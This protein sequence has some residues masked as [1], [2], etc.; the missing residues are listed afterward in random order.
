[1]QSLQDAH[2]PERR[3]AGRVSVRP[4]PELRGKKQPVPRLSVLSLVGKD[5]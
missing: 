3:R 2:F 1:M 4:T 5:G